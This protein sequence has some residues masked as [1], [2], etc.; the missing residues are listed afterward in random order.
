MRADPLNSAS[1]HRANL[2]TVLRLLH[3]HG[4][5]SRAALTRDT[6]LNRSTIAKLVAALAERGLVEER[7]PERERRVGRPSPVVTPGGQAVA[8]AANPEVDAIE[9]AAVALGGRVLL[10]TRIPTDRPSSPERAAALVLRTVEEWREQ[11]LSGA[12]IVGLGLAIPG[13]VNAAD[14]RI[15]LAP[16]LGW[17]EVDLAQPLRDAL[18]LP[19]ELDNDAALGARAEH[20]FGAAA[21]HSDVV[22]LNGGA[23][24]IG[25]GIILGSA[26]V[27]GASGYAGEWGQTRPVILNER[28]RRAD[29]VLEDEVNR[30]RLLDVLG[31]GSADDPELARLLQSADGALGEELARQRR[32][33]AAT[34][35]GVVNGLNPG[36]IVLGGFL[37]MLYEGDPRGFLAELRAEALP[38]PGREV[39][40]A[41][42]GLAENRLLVGAADLAFEPLLADPAGA[43]LAPPPA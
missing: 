30:N 15:R 42:A 9:M 29:G 27:R 21:G 25:G 18:G 28:D 1:L 23:S 26:L 22:Y 33:L 40:V 5:R 35:A 24:G 13:L 8:I 11:R 14:H 17:E 31:V 37:G 43:I 36:L 16:H 32:I 2:S 39:R 6:G 3:Q 41:T 4:P 20:L 12:R 10:R 34:L 19:V 38:A 7:E